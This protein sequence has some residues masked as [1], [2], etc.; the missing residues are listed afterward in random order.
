MEEYQ[1][2]LDSFLRV[3]R[4]HVWIE[5]TLALTA[6]LFAIAL[7]R[8]KRLFKPSGFIM[9]SVGLLLDMLM[10]H[11][12]PLEPWMRY[13]RAAAVTLVLFGIIR[14]LVETVLVTTHRRTTELSTIFFGLL[15]AALYGS[16]ALLVLWLVV[17]VNP[18]FL[19]A[20]PVLGTLVLG[21]ILQSDFLHGVLLQY[22]RPF[23]PGDWVRIGSHLGRV[24][25]TGWR[26]TRLV[27]RSK[28]NIQ[29]PNA[30][31]AKEL[32]INYSAADLVADEVCIGLGYET[33]PDIVEQTIHTLLRGIPEVCKGEVDV[34]EYGESAIR[35]RIR[36]WI[37]DYATQEQ[38]RTQI[39]R[40][41]WYS[42]RRSA[43][44]IPFPTRKILTSGDQPTASTEEDTG[45]RLIGDLRRVYPTLTDEELELLTPGIRV[46]QFG[47]GEI[48]IR[49]GENGDCFYVLR[50]GQVEVAARKADGT[51]ERHVGY[52][53]ESSP[54]NFFGERALLTGEPRNATIRAATDVEVLEISRDGFT[55]LFRTK[56][57]AASAIADI[58]ARREAETN[59]IRASADGAPTSK[60]AKVLAMIYRAF[61]IQK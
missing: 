53:D 46:K 19:L 15:N 25:E 35:Y 39:L 56:P 22:Q 29:I 49:E 8:Q 4:A 57:E 33:S 51:G 16:V 24:R 38:V 10:P 2:L 17:G 5:A 60:A 14:L 31:L 45:R 3:V 28:E 42:L 48:V 1:S 50:D 9:L 47:R 44:E 43:I 20:V 27:T 37:A 59:Q 18:R 26:A 55:Q 41:L 12:Q 52:M 11:A 7:R 58:A 21:W 54:E 40:S 13:W 61:D 32:T 6:A 36:F 30:L 23:A 34:W